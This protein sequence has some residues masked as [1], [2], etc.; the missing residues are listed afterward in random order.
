MFLFL[1]VIACN[2]NSTEPQDDIRA[3]PVIKKSSENYDQE[4]FRISFPDTTS[5][6][7]I[8]KYYSN[9]FSEDKRNKLIEYITGEVTKLGEDAN[10]FNNILAITGCKLSDEYLLPTYAERAKYEGEEVWIFQITYGLGEPNFGHY[11]CF[12]FSIDTLDTLDYVGCK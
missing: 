9:N 7:N 1:F 11:K 2:E 10:S 3:K 8:S 6:N 12:A 5:L 4:S